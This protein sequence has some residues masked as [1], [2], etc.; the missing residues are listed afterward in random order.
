MALL[1]PKKMMKLSILLTIVLLSFRGSSAGHLKDSLNEWLS[2]RVV[3]NDSDC[4]QNQWK[5][6]L[7]STISQDNERVITLIVQYPSKSVELQS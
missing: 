6:Q 5:N 7:F 2:D 4:F 3:S 1:T